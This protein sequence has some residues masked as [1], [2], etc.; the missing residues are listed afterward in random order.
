MLYGAPGTGKT[1]ATNAL[2]KFLGWKFFTID[3]TQYEQN[4]VGSAKR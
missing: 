4:S 2:A 3:A 1:Y